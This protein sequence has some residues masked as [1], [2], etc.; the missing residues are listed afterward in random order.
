MLKEEEGMLLI[1]QNLWNY[2]IALPKDTVM[3]INLAWVDDPA[4]LAEMVSS[5][6]NA[7]FLDVPTGRKKPPNNR[8][9][10]EQVAPVLAQHPN[11]RYV[12][13]SNV[14]GGAVIEQFRSVLG[15]DINLVPKIETRVGIGNIAAIRDSL[16]D[17]ATMM[18]DHD[19]LFND[20][21][22]SEGDAAEYTGL[23]DQL[24]DFC[25]ANGVCLLRTRGV[26]FSDTD[27]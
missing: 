16:G 4:D 13:I 7:V 14:E 5:V 2:D 26:I 1:S 11:I 19:D 20:V 21:M 8:Y 18:L 3:R 6:Q 10:L 27:A 15:A 24:I 9:S 17:D 12:A 22:T 25:D 23:I